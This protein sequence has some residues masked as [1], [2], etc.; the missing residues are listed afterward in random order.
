MSRCDMELCPHWGGDGDVC[1][2]AV[3]D[4]P[5]PSCTCDGGH[6]L[7][8]SVH[9]EEAMQLIGRLADGA[10]GDTEQ[11]TEETP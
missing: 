1:P 5:R 3:F 11:T 8:C 4:L 9:A 7:L 2:C 6:A 10:T